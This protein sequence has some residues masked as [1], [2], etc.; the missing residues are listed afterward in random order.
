MPVNDIFDTLGCP[1]RMKGKNNGLPILRFLYVAIH[2]VVLQQQAIQQ[3][4]GIDTAHVRA[5]SRQVH[6]L[7]LF[8]KDH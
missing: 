3:G 1:H 4:H 7:V 8:E 2:T 5:R 6:D